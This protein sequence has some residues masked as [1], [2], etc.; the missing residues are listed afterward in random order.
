M[1]QGEGSA[2]RNNFLQVP[3]TD[4]ATLPKVSTLQCS[5]DT[6]EVIAI[7]NELILCVRGCRAPIGNLEYDSMRGLNLD[8]HSEYTP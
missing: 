2:N 1:H 6:L 5:Q 8:D 7:G 4:E 3:S